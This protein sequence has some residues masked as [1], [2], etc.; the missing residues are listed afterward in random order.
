MVPGYTLTT[1]PNVICTATAATKVETRATTIDNKQQQSAVHSQQE[2]GTVHKL[3]EKIRTSG[4]YL[5]TRGKLKRRRKEEFHNLQFIRE[6]GQ[7]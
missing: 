2:I 7:T 5:T 4:F 1:F 6:K 3:V